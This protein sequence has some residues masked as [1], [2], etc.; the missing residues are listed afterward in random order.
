MKNALITSLA[1]AVLATAA[2]AQQINVS[3]AGGWT[4]TPFSQS[5]FLQFSQVNP[6]SQ[7]VIMGGALAD[8]GSSMSNW[9]TRGSASVQGY[10]VGGDT[11]SG[12]AS[13]TAGA[14]E[15]YT[16][17]AGNGTV[18]VTLSAQPEQ[19]T[20]AL[21]GSGY[22]GTVTGTVAVTCS[23]FGWLTASAS[24][25]AVAPPAIPTSQTNQVT[26]SALAFNQSAFNLNM[27]SGATSS[28]SLPAGSQMQLFAGANATGTVTLN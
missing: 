15:F 21:R 19:P 13:R 28:G 6:T 10:T 5:N 7:G 12:S 3:L 16:N 27:N 17:A 8:A 9:F 20:A 11:V 4:V 18:L 22:S 24:A 23:Y 26:A 1:V 14:T 25:T 2:S